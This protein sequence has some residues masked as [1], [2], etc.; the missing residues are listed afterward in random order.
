MIHYLD[1]HLGYDPRLIL[2]TFK[3]K[4]SEY[5]PIKDKKKF[6]TFL[7]DL[8]YERKFLKNI[9]FKMLLRDNK[10]KLFLADNM[11]YYCLD[12]KIGRENHIF[13]IKNNFFPEEV[14][15]KFLSIEDIKSFE[16]LTPEQTKQFLLKYGWIER[17]DNLRLLFDKKLNFEAEKIK[18][19]VDKHYSKKHRMQ[20]FFKAGGPSFLSDLL[21]FYGEAQLN[22]FNY[23]KEIVEILLKTSFIAEETLNGYQ[24]KKKEFTYLV[25]NAFLK[26]DIMEIKKILEAIIE[27]YNIEEKIS[28]KNNIKHNKI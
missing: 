14:I 25:E 19:F 22:N 28:K 24:L 10:E 8:N 6:L 12:D 9:D 7:L 27:Q 17:E 2:D 20:Y 5:L 18:I 1:E 26:E 11:V 23:Q 15:W 4:R 21:F 16:F 3:V 13:L